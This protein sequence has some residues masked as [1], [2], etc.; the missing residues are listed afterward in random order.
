MPWPSGDIYP[1]SK[2][3]LLFPHLWPRECIKCSMWPLVNWLFHASLYLWY[4]IAFNNNHVTRIHFLSSLSSYPLRN[5]FSIIQNI[6][7][8]STASIQLVM[9]LSSK[10]AVVLTF[11]RIRSTIIKTFLGTSLLSCWC[12]FYCLWKESSLWTS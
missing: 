4:L 3:T 9:T 1:S 2:S 11:Q 6:L 10:L 8:V 12:L 7:D 5:S